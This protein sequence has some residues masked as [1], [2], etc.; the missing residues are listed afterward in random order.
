MIEHG[1]RIP[2]TADDINAQTI[3]KRSCVEA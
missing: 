2:L 3:N 1:L